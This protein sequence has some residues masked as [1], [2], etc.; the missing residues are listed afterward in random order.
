MFFRS[1]SLVRNMGSAGADKF[2][3]P[4]TSSFQ[5]GQVWS[6]RHPHFS[7]FPGCNMIA[8]RKGAVCIRALSMLILQARWLSEVLGAEVAAAPVG[9]KDHEDHDSHRTQIR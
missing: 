4:F 5:N 9:S 7:T 2:C 3:A 1:A 6:G 8:H